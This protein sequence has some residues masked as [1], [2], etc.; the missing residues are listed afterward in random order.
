MIKYYYHKNMKEFLLFSKKEFNSNPNNFNFVKFEKK[1]NNQMI[2]INKNKKQEILF[3]FKNSCKCKYKK[4]IKS[5]YKNFQNSKNYNILNYIKDINIKKINIKNIKKFYSFL[6]LILISFIPII[7]T[8]EIKLRQLYTDSEIIMTIK[9]TGYKY[10]LN[11][12]FSSKPSKIFI[13]DI[14]E[15]EIDEQNLYDLKDEENKVK[16]I[17]NYKLVNL[18]NM[19]KELTDITNINFDNFDTS[20]V[21]E[22]QGMF[23]GCTSLTSLDLKNFDTKSVNNMLD[24]FNRCSS[25]K[26]LDLSNFITSSV[27]KMI[28]M[29]YG[30]TSLISLNLDN[31]DTSNVISMQSM[32][33]ECNLLKS[34]NLDSFDT[35]KVISMESMFKYCYKLTSL[36]LKSF[37]TKSVTS[38]ID[39]F[40]GCNSLEFLDLNNFDTSSVTYMNAMFYDCNKLTSLLISNF[41]TSSVIGMSNMFM[42]CKSLI[43]LDLSNFNTKSTLYMKDLFNRC[44]SLIYL[45]LKNFDTSLISEFNAMFYGCIS[46]TSLDLSSF[47]TSSAES[48]NSM[49]NG[50]KSLKFLNLS[51]FDT[52]KV[53]DMYGMFNGCNALLSLDLNSFDTSEVIN[54]YGIF[55]SCSS[56]ISLYLNNFDTSSI[57]EFHNMFVNTN[58][59]LIYCFNKGEMKAEIKNFLTNFK[60]DCDDA[61]FTNNQNKFIVEKNQ[62]IDN[63]YKDDTYRF[64][65]NSICYVSCPKGTHISSY[66]EFIC[67]DDLI[68]DNYYNYTH[69]GCID[70]IPDG[71][72]LNDSIHKTIDKC[73]IQCNK[74]SNYSVEI[75]LCISCN[76]NEGYYQKYKDIL[77]VD[78]FIKCY[79][80]KPESYY[81][82]KKDKIYKPCLLGCK[83]CEEFENEK[84]KCIECNSDLILINNKCY[85]NCSYYYYFDKENNYHCTLDYECTDNGYNKLIIEKNECI[86][87]CYN[88]QEYIYEFNNICYKICPSGTVISSTNKYL[89]EKSCPSNY[90]YINKKTN[91]CINNCSAIE[92]LNDICGIRNNNNYVK[93]IMIKKIGDEIKNG[94]LDKLILKVINGD[95]TDI[96]KVEDDTS[97]QITLSSNQNKYEYKNI[98]SIILGD[99]ETILRNIYEI[100]DNQQSLIILKIDYF[101]PYSLIPIIGYEIFHPKNKSKLDLSYCK[102]K[103]ISFKIPVSIDEN[104]LFKYDPND[105]YYKN[106]CIIYTTENG[107]DILINDRKEEY[108]INNLSICENNCLFKRYEKTTKKTECECE[109]KYKQIEIVEVAE[110]KD[111]LTHDFS[112][113]KESSDNFAL[114]CFNTLFSVEGLSKNIGSYILIFSFCSFIILGIIFY[115]I[116]N[117]NIE[118]NIKDIILSKMVN[119]NTNIKNNGSIDKNNIN[120]NTKDNTDSILKLKNKHNISNRKALSS[121]ENINSISN[122]KSISKIELGNKNE[123]IYPNK[124]INE[125]S[126]ESKLDNLK[127]YNNYELNTL[128]YKEA[129]KYDK[130]SLGN[131]YISLIRSKHPLIFSV[132]PLK[133]YNSMIIK[134]SLFFLSF[135]IYYFLNSLF[136]DESTIHKI[137]LDK[138]KFNLIYLLPNAIYSFIISH[139]LCTVIIYF[140][141]SE[142]NI[143]E[144]K[145][146]SNYEK[147]N[148]KGLKMKKIL[149]IKYICFF[150]LGSV[151]ILFF[152]YYISS[153]GAV[154]PNTQELLIENALISYIFSIVYCFI[155][156]LLPGILRIYSLKDSN[157]VSVYKLSKI[158]QF[159]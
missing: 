17:W 57:K 75:N 12:Y 10:V 98:S 33:M 82:D 80:E 58:T 116:G 109:I 151:F 89:C 143:I 62:C 115:K 118:I 107:T 11:Q 148:I 44:E 132:F 68:C 138:G 124:N 40:N 71:F 154:F 37:N 125:L 53:T 63:C 5:N 158:I 43:K 60:N 28:A 35:S 127:N 73:D 25:L 22:M 136:F 69:T 119:E 152:W 13:N 55:Q 14:E 34:L 131:Y 129:I 156:N 83:I 145:K 102:D 128:S 76:N 77:N 65:Y 135:D 86:D 42:N 78:T 52:A 90:Y 26:S 104:N 51:S 8:K 48:M 29:F 137:Y 24:M 61:C 18:V 100:N 93:D 120:L 111:I 7:I 92:F 36:N 31:F 16:M 112:D 144:I 4:I 155:I 134:I 56:L 110:I 67:E 146:E 106:Q 20:S 114:K 103:N 46:L 23:M 95:I 1:Y 139:I 85:E 41:D 96:L 30:C 9:G 79:N 117:D 122:P 72:Y 105:E 27:T 153:F 108:N 19:F 91:E 81:L 126:V 84:I 64:E 133:D 150:S 59:K 88:D 121:P 3:D 130:R 70:I 87:H 15:R 159:I 6:L 50:C 47:K 149:K 142:R 2:D 99:C 141:L 101:K 97:Y 32:F 157:K 49:F 123:L 45:N 54:M 140:S 38:M 113:L 66:N 147:A 21:T 74:C 94:T 39:M